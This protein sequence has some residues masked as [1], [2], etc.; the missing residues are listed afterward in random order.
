MNDEEKEKALKPASRYLGLDISSEPP[1]G[2]WWSD[3]F[4]G[5]IEN[6]WF[7]YVPPP[8]NMLGGGRCLIIS[9]ATGEVVGSKSLSNS[10]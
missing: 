7:A 2:L 6:Y 3:F 10:E 9:K 8:S 1:E 5:P 4:Y